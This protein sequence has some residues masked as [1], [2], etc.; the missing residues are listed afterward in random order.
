MRLQ[1]T[2]Q[3][4]PVRQTEEPQKLAEAMVECF[5]GKGLIKLSFT[6]TAISP[7][8]CCSG[9]LPLLDIKASAWGYTK[10]EA[11]RN[12]LDMLTTKLAALIKLGQNQTVSEAKT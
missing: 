10:L 5:Q 8:A 4:S 11:E 3:R 1:K 12:A 9:H 7:H 2:L 6:Y